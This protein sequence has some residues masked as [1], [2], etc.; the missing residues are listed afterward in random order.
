[1]ALG[2]EGHEDCPDFYFA[3][4]LA[5]RDGRISRLRLT[6]DP[7]DGVDVGRFDVDLPVTTALIERLERSLRAAFAPSDEPV[8]TC[9]RD[10]LGDPCVLR[11]PGGD[12]LSANP[13]PQ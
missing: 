1:V 10:S 8:T 4:L 11:P 6:F 13:Q 9:H 12:A 5:G 3:R 7:M 2:A